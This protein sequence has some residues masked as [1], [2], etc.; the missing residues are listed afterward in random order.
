MFFDF[1]NL[2]AIEDI[3]K[4]IV[5]NRIELL[6]ASKFKYKNNNVGNNIIIAVLL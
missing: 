1:L 2:K 5:D 3:I 4:S 6:N